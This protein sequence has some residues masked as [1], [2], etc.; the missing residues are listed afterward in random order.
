[1]RLNGSWWRMEQKSIKSGTV[2]ALSLTDITPGR[3]SSRLL[4]W[5]RKKV[6]IF[7]LS[8]CYF[9]SNAVLNRYSHL[10]SFLVNEDYK[11][12]AETYFFLVIIYEYFL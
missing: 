12:I 1:M 2:K 4:L 7:F 5:D 9:G 6:L 3:L 8:C 11:L 10:A